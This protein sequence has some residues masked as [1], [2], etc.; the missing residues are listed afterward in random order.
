VDVVEAIV[1]NLSWAWPAVAAAK[2]VNTTT[3]SSARLIVDIDINFIA[4]ATHL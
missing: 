2:P 3:D 1:M 4:M